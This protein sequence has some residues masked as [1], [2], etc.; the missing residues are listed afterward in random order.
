YRRPVP[1]STR[2]ISSSVGAIYH[3]FGDK[4]GLRAAVIERIMERLV[5]GYLRPP[6]LEEHDSPTRRLVESTLAYVRFTEENYDDFALLSSTQHDPRESEHAQRFSRGTIRL[7]TSIMGQA[8][9]IVREGQES[10]EIRRGDPGGMVV[11]VWSALYGM[12]T[13]VRRYPGPVRGATGQVSSSD[14]AVLL[15]HA[16]ISPDVQATPA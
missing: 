1:P 15:V 7:V 13:L 9:D 11:L 12:C 14:L 3:H 4:E 5:E 6:F 2:M 10:G 8:I 16:A